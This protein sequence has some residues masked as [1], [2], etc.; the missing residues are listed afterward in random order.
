MTDNA[1]GTED[2]S[3][4]LLEWLYP[5]AFSLVQAGQSGTPLITFLTLYHPQVKASSTR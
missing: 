1:Q 4:T 2:Q 3:G 5:F